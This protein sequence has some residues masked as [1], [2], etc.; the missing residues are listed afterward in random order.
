MAAASTP[1]PHVCGPGGGG[2]TFFP[3]FE[4]EHK[5]NHAVRATLYGCAMIY[6]FLGVNIVADKFVSSIETITSRKRR[7]WSK[8]LVRMVTLTTWNATVAN[9]TLMALGS[10][11]PEI[12]LSM[13]EIIL[14]DFFGGELGPSTI[15]GSAAF[16]LFV[17]VAV[18]VAVIPSPEVRK[19]KEHDVFV[20]TAVFSLFAY[21]W[22]VFIVQIASPDIVEIW[23]ALVTL[24]LFPALILVSYL[25]DIGK[26]PGLRRQQASVPCCT[27]DA[28]RGTDLQGIPSSSMSEVPH[29]QRVHSWPTD[30]KM[31]A[32]DI[33]QGESTSPTETAGDDLNASVRLAEPVKDRQG[34]VIT[35]NAGVISFERDT[36]SVCGGS[37][38][39][40]VRVSVL[41]LNGNEGTVTCKYRMQKLTAVPGYDYDD[42]A[43][44]EGILEFPPSITYAEIPFKVLRKHL[45]EHSDQ[46]Q[47]VLEDITGG[48][49]FNPNDDGGEEACVLTVTILNETDML[50]QQNVL[51][52]ANRFMDRMVNCDELRLTASTWLDEVVDSIIS[53]SGEDDA[54]PT[55]TDWAM[56]IVSIPWKF[57]FAVLIPPSALAGGW[58]CFVVSI[59]FIGFLTVMVIDF[60]ELFGCVTGIADSITAIT[61]VA[62]GTSM[63]DLFASMTAAVQDPDADASIVNVT[64]SNSVNVFL[65]IGLPWTFAAIY[66]AVTGA[67]PEWKKQYKEFLPRYPDGAFVVK[68]GDLG[69][70]V[71]VFSLAACICLGVIRFRRIKLGGEL[72]GPFV[73]KVFSAVLLVMLW[74]FYVT[75]SIWKVEAHGADIAKQV[76]AV[77]IGLIILENIMMITA[78]GIWCSRCCRK[79]TDEVD[80]EAACG[81]DASNATVHDESNLEHLRCAGRGADHDNSSHLHEV[82]RSSSVPG[83][84]ERSPLT[85]A[86]L[87]RRRVSQPARKT[88]LPTL[89][90]RESVQRQSA[91]KPFR[92][93]ANA[94]ASPE[95]LAHS[96]GVGALPQ[97]GFLQH[98]SSF[99][100]LPEDPGPQGVPPAAA[101]SPQAEL[102]PSPT[103]SGSWWIE[104][105]WWAELASFAAEHCVSSGSTGP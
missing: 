60:A 97:P 46:F 57:A 100:S 47:I 74:M 12:M 41:R 58:I 45:G 79:R 53:V 80:P 62:L 67:T 11:A 92:M 72:G 83:E 51:L 33:A 31:T 98:S 91:A 15:V 24:L 81:E 50:T 14:G 86:A 70:S 73:P 76:L 29:M 5:W 49:V 27:P 101:P 61:I 21:F 105:R 48:A 37:E 3:L 44:N 89:M 56:H 90:T 103:E 35:N 93:L 20:I 65:G 16:N 59:G 36:M 23:E 25:A 28:S 17:I 54:Q 77:F 34:H 78:V 1:D 19:I 18:C 4:S 30:G 32:V 68:G 8:K 6:L 94:P 55:F 95:S 99:H 13:S 63:P 88:D 26:L 22:L 2:G 66:W 96:G 40:M 102:R 71:I 52:K 10:S 9:L 82:S 7:V 69:F 85:I 87:A 38:E 39:R 104:G 84:P 75:L 64:G 42:P 43:K